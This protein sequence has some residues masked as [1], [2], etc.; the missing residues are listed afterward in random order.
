MSGIEP[1]TMSIA[2]VMNDSNNAAI[3]PQLPPAPTRPAPL[4]AKDGSGD[5]E[6]IDLP[7]Q[8]TEEMDDAVSDTTLVDQDHP[9]TVEAFKESDTEMKDATAESQPAR[10]LLATAKEP[11]VSV[12]ELSADDEAIEVDQWEDISEEKKEH[13]EQTPDKPPVPPRNK[14]APIDTSGR[15]NKRRKLEFGAQQDVTEVIGNLMFNLQCAIKPTGF[16]PVFG[17]QIDT[18]KETFYGSNATYLQ[19]GNNVD[20]KIEPW[21]NLIVF[22]DTEGSRTLY[23][24]LDVVFDEQTVEIDNTNAKQWASVNQLPPVLQ[25]QIQRTQYDP[26]LGASKN[27]NKIEFDETI[28]LDRYMDSKKVLQRRRESGK[29]KSQLAELIEHQKILEEKRYNMS[30]AEVYDNAKNLLTSIQ[31]TFDDDFEIINDIPEILG[32]RSLDLKSQID[33]IEKQKQEVKAMIREDFTDMRDYRY[34]LQAVFI[35]KGGSGSGHHWVYIYD[36]KNDVWREYNDER[37]EIVKDRQKVFG[38]EGWSAT[39]PRPATAH[40]LVYVRDDQ[41]ND[42]VDAVCREMDE[43]AAPGE[44]AQPHWDNTMIVDSD[45]SQAM[46]VEYNQ[47]IEQQVK[48][49]GSAW[50][51]L[52]RDDEEISPSSKVKPAK[53]PDWSAPL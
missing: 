37:V 12:A 27:Q 51:S 20:R 33:S 32:Q 44:V 52:E 39:D 9:V 43:V 21:A 7:A 6:M 10:F 5:V 28:F 23:E 2:A 47:E 41:K 15:N 24:A 1:S 30:K 31:E 40:Y 34:V 14:P 26:V 16:D 17:E 13:R 49:T 25:I 18:V 19:K 22:P 42:L 11:V 53:H 29:R 38:N 45:K 48:G 35:H 3:G 4:P 50:S 36:F 46:H 8:E